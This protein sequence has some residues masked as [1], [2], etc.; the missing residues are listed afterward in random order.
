MGIGGGTSVSIALAAEA[1]THVAALQQLLQQSSNADSLLQ[2]ISRLLPVHA[3]DIPADVARRL[4]SQLLPSAAAAAAAA[5][6]EAVE[7]D[8][9]A[10][11][12]QQ[13]LERI[14][15]KCVVEVPP[16]VALASW[17]EDLL[18]FV[19]STLEAKTCVYRRIKLAAAAARERNA[20]V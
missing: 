14:S 20:S 6:A 10:A 2:Q 19:R 15:R 17:L 3:S 8:K 18:E 12:Q 1:E 7:S 11:A 16:E 13:A 4:T 9:T 5:D